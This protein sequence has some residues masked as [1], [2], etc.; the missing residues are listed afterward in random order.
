MGVSSR[1]Q[2][3]QEVEVAGYV[4]LSKSIRFSAQNRLDVVHRTPE[5]SVERLSTDFGFRNVLCLTRMLC[6]D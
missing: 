2:R 3:L 6:P 1:C 4:V 5:A